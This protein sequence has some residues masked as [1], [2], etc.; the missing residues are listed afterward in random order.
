MT[1]STETLPNSNEKA[2]VVREMF[3]RIAPSYDRMN[4]LM[5][6][7][8]DRAW[9]R[10]LLQTASVGPGDVLVDV[11]CGTGDIGLLAR[12]EG[13]TV[14]GVDF[15]FPMLGI[16]ADRGLAG[17][18]SRGDALSLPIADDAV[19]AVTCGFGLRNFVAIPPFVEEAARVLKPGGRIVLLEVATPSNPLVR[20]GHQL[21]F[22]RVV[23]I[24][25]ALVTER[26]AYTYL[27]QSVV[28]LPSTEELVAMLDRAGFMRTGAK[29]LGLGGIQIVHGVR[30]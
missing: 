1:M 25:G 12:R 16:A 17:R 10:T 3:D 19:D 24:L 20:F 6:G 29:K 26:K 14:V 27:P 21:Y 11:A 5:T 13:A 7:G 23:P 4:S 30:P 18:L 15:S 2:T 9:R 28:Y 8:F 22:N